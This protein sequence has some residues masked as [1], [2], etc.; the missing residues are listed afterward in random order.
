[1]SVITDCL[2]DLFTASNGDLLNNPDAWGPMGG[3]GGAPGYYGNYSTSGGEQVNEKVVI[4]DDGTR[5][6]I[7]MPAQ[8]T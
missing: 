3:F 8:E 6:L 2:R 4:P 7:H 5:I 1:M